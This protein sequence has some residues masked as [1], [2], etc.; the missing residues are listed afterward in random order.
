[1][2]FLLLSD[3]RM[4]RPVYRSGWRT[5]KNNMS[6]DEAFRDGNRALRIYNV[7]DFNANNGNIFIRFR[8]FDPR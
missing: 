4:A 3:T 6:E 1:M 8:Y 5:T 2:G 7:N